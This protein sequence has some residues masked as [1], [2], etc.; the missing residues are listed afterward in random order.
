MK[1]FLK[2]C[3]FF[4]FLI[5]FAS[6]ANEIDIFRGMELYAENCSSCHMGNLSGHPE[7][8]TT[9]DEDGHRRSP[10]L[11]GTAHTWHHSPEWLFNVIR[12]GFIKMDPNYEGKMLGNESL[13]DEDIWSILAFIKSVWPEDIVN[14]YD[15]YFDN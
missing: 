2:V 6:Y 11:N 3:L 13:S 9:L 15:A 10:P 12:Y 1:L 8:K 5:S 14:K 4:T 7:W